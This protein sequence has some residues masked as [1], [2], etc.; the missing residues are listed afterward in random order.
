MVEC[1]IAIAEEIAVLRDF[2][3]IATS[4]FMHSWQTSLCVRLPQINYVPHVLASADLSQVLDVVLVLI[5]VDVVNLL[6]RKTAFANSPDG[7]VQINNNQFLAYSA[8]NGQVAFFTMLLA[9]YRSAQSAA[10]Q[11]A[12]ISIVSVVLSYAKQQFL[13][14]RFCQV[15]LVHNSH[16]KLSCSHPSQL[17]SRQGKYL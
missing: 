6:F 2:N 17:S 3:P 14:L 13:L 15:F 9:S 8:I 11:P 16:F 12:S 1:Q 4:V 10:R 5:A 7:M